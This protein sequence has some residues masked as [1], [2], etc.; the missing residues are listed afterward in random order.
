MQPGVPRRGAAA[1]AAANES[2]ARGLDILP[3]NSDGHDTHSQAQRVPVYEIRLVKARRGLRLAESTVSDAE[4]AARTL[5]ALIGLTDREHFAAIFLRGVHQLS[6]EAARHR[7]EDRR[8]RC[9]HR[10]PTWDGAIE[11]RT[12]F[13]AAIAA[14]ASG[15]LVSHYVPRHIMRLL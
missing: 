9:G 2:Q 7:V 15:L 8:P 12:L 3:R 10:R 14:C 4:L 11:A 13:R 1:R 6:P 5:H